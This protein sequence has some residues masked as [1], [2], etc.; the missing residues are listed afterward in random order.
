[1]SAFYNEIISPEYEQI[2]QPATYARELQYDIVGTSDT[3]KLITDTLK[4]P[5]RYI[6]HIQTQESGGSFPATG[7]F[8]GPRSILTAGHVLWDAVIN[9][10]IPRDK[11][12]LTPARNGSLKPVFG[13][14][15]PTACFFSR[16]DFGNKDHVTARDYAIMHI[17]EPVGNKTGYWGMGI[18]KTD[19]TGSS[20]LKAGLPLPAKDLS[21]NLCGYPSD[22][23][24]GTRQYLS[25][26][27]GFKLIDDK[28]V[29]TYFNDTKGG[30]SGS[31]V[32]VRRHHSMGGRVLI[33][34]HTGAGPNAKRG[35]VEYNQAVFITD[36]V[37]AFIS[38]H[39]L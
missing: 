27:K 34:I 10:A 25:F 1:M 7:F 14:F 13:S 33:G 28:K 18:T 29:L 6:C 2:L 16:P 12:T 15:S 23:A 36:E 38:K 22:K 26:N 19:P 39:R 35:G 17:A 4:V 8:I 5:F 37:R 3:R 21:M 31:P 32:W 9:K 30:H 24:G 11:L 20:I